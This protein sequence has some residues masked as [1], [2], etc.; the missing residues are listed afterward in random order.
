MDRVAKFGGCT[1]IQPHWQGIGGAMLHAGSSWGLCRPPQGSRRLIGSHK[2]HKDQRAR[3]EID[4]G[5]QKT[6]CN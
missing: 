1:S 2:S 4:S 5:V 6:V 3:P